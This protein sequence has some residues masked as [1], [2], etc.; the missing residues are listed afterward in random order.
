MGASIRQ[1][2]S[3]LNKIRSQGHLKN[4]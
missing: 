1:R 3:S 2:R 4:R